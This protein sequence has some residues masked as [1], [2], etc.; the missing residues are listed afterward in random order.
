[1]E[2][3]MVKH[4]CKVA[5]CTISIS[6]KHFP[7]RIEVYT[8]DASLANLI[9]S[10]VIG[11]ARPPKTPVLFHSDCE[12]ALVNGHCGK[13]GCSPDMQSTYLE[14]VDETDSQGTFEVESS[15]FPD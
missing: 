15:E 11:V 1:M 2:G 7:D 14:L 9:N 8:D 4:L 5:G 13:C 6:H 3:T 12:T 10:T